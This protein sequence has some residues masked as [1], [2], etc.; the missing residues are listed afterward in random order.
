MKIVKLPSFFLLKDKYLSPTILSLAQLTKRKEKE[1]EIDFSELKEMRKG[2]VMVLYAQ[3]EKSI[4]INKNKIYRK[5]SLP[6]IKKIKELLMS[7]SIIHHEKKKIELPEISDSEKE[8]LLY[9]KLI[10][11]IVNDLKKIGIKEYF[12][13]FNVFLTELIGNAVEHGIENRNI[14]WW[15]TQE[16]DRQTKVTKYTF[17]DMG[18]GII[19]SHK[20]AGLPLKYMFLKKKKILLDALNGKLGS[21][22]KQSNRGKGL[23]QLREMIEKE[24]VTNLILITNS[25]S[26]YFQNNIFFTKKNPNFV[27]TYYSW[28]IDQNNYQKWKNSQ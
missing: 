19:D 8:K 3:I 1:F 24:Y 25:V 11:I 2:D 10:D 7:P 5:G 6:T 22:T 28:T 23:P 12:Y 4:I 18:L 15:L 26:L 16:I 14:N 13:P 17:V 9:P 20:K 27:G 21:S